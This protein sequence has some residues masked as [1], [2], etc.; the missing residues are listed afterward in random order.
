MAKRKSRTRETTTTR[1]AVLVGTALGNVAGRVDNW[2]AQRDDI[3]KELNAIIGRAQGMLASIGASAAKMGR[4]AADAVGTVTKTANQRR[5]AAR[6][7]G[8]ARSAGAK[9]APRA[10]RRAAKKAKRA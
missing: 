9:A 7:A 10:K 6:A 2:L 1:A 3:A 5:R 8:K 4:R